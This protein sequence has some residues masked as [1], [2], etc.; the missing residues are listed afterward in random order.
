[1]SA[2]TIASVVLLAV[3]VAWLGHVVA[4]TWRQLLDEVDADLVKRDAS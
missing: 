2:A 1:M 3:L 4:G